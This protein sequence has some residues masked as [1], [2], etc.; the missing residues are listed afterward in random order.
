MFEDN[1]WYGHRKILLKYCSLKD[2]N[3]YASIQHGWNN[4][5]PIDNLEKLKATKIPGAI[6][7]CWNKKIE[8]N[9]KKRNYSNVVSIGAPFLYLSDHFKNHENNGT[10][11]FPPHSDVQNNYYVKSN[12][13]LIIKNIKNNYPEPYTVCLFYS[14][15][16]KDI[17]D[18]YENEKVEVVSCG[19][20]LSDSF[21]I[22]FINFVKKKEY[23]VVNDLSSAYLYSLYLKKKTYLLTHINLLGKNN[24]IKNI[25][26]NSEGNSIQEEEIKKIATYYKVFFDNDYNLEK[27]RNFALEELGYDSFKKPEKLKKLLG[28]N[29]F[30]KNIG[31]KVIFSIKKLIQ[32]K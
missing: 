16:I 11:V 27:K 20:R 1:N 21:L 26:R 24:S 32:H 23:V 17:I 7:L 30:Y 5:W 22:N 3:V 12:H 6:H 9:Y 18:Q 19:N 28:L 29:N 31:A 25:W 4:T 15:L 13:K 2:Q 8:K 14:D 10:I